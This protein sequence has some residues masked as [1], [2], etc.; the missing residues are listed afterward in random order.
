MTMKLPS[1]SEGSKGRGT[2]SSLPSTASL[3]DFGLC[4]GRNNTEVQ[5]GFEQ[6]ADFV[7]GHSAGTDQQRGAAFEFEEDG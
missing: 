7:E 5:A 6:A 1:R 3:A 2:H 4:F